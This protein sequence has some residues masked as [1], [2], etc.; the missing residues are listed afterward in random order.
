MERKDYKQIDL[1][2]LEAQLD[3]ISGEEV[4]I[5][6]RE[7][8]PGTILVFCSGIYKPTPD[9]LKVSPYRY[10][11]KQYTDEN[12][13]KELKEIVQHLFDKV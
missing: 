1:L 5:K 2:F 12:M 11:L 6:F 10:L 9:F 7:Y 8:Y 13:L 4:A 3:G